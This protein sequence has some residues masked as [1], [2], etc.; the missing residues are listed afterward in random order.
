[1]NWI[2]IVGIGLMG[3]SLAKALKGFKGAKIR[4]IDIDKNAIEEALRLGVIDE[5]GEGDADLTILCLTP[6]KNIEYIRNH[7]FSGLVTD[8]TGVKA[9]IMEEAKRKEIDFIGGHPMAGRE[10]GGWEHSDSNLFR[11][12][13]YILVKGEN[14]PE[15]ACALMESM[16]AYIGCSRVIYATAE[17]HDE[18][19]AFTSQM[20][21]ILASALTRDPVFMAS[22]G[23][24]GNSFRGAAR[25]AELDADMWTEL[26]MRNAAPLADC[27]DRLAHGLLE[28][29]DI[30]R[31]KDAQELK[32]RLAEG[33]QKKREWNK[34]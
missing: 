30:I 6:G 2:K 18:R 4:A 7:K 25:V 17:E 19:I 11:G 31:N 12:A 23:F 26:F 29:E 5:A 14:T 21:H 34:I 13:N 16:C 28:Y 3:G 20:M 8:I 27:I 10:K 9:D 22:R 15:Y 32:L 1:M 33:T 24:D